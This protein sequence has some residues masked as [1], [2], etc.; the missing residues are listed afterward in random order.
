MG[1]VGQLVPIAVVPGDEPEWH[2]VVDGF[3][4]V[5]VARQLRQDTVLAV[6]WN[7]S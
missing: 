7:L 6:E 3:A 1:R 2:V 4:R 5:R